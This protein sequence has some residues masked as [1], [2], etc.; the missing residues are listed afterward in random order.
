MYLKTARLSIFLTIFFGKNLKEVLYLM[1]LKLVQ[2]LLVHA[3]I[4]ECLLMHHLIPLNKLL[5]FKL[6]N[7]SYLFNN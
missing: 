6:F 3:E 4:G 5:K 1:D 7:L 2:S